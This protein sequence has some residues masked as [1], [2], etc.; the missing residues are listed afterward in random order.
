M[1]P[2]TEEKEEMSPRVKALGKEKEDRNKE[3]KREE[4]DK[5][6]KKK[7]RKKDQKG[8]ITKHRWGNIGKKR[9]ERQKG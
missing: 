4:K 6:N 9:K 5:E 7:E 3:R 2:F 8:G 1:L